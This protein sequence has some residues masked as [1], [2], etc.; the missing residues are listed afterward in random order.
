M[1]ALNCKTGKFLVFDIRQQDKDVHS[2]K[3][4]DGPKAQKNTWIDDSTL[5]TS[6]FNK[7]A[8]REY[9]IWD[10]RNFDKPVC[11]AALGN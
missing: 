9:A 7:Q 11:R 8:E 6:G 5:M 4:H 2:I 1:M 10:L 3:C